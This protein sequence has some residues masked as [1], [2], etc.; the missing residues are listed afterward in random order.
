MCLMVETVERGGGVKLQLGL[1]ET[2]SA[3]VI[4]DRV[5]LHVTFT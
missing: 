2:A 1:I 4:A 3:V 5:F